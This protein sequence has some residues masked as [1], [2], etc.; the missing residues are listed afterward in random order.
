M[1]GEGG[2]CSTCSRKHARG[3][4]D[5]RR[6][7]GGDAAAQEAK[8]ARKQQTERLALL[9]LPFLRGKHLMLTEKAN[10]PLLPKKGESKK[11]EEARVKQLADKIAACKQNA[12]VFTRV[13]G[14]VLSEGYKWEPDAFFVREGHHIWCPRGFDRNWW[15]NDPEKAG[16]WVQ[17]QF[18]P[19]ER[20][21]VQVP[22]AIDPRTHTKSMADYKR[23]DYNRALAVLGH[24]FA[25]VPRAKF[26][27]AEGKVALTNWESVRLRI[28][29]LVKKFHPD[30]IPAECEVSDVWN[31]F[32][33]VSKVC[34]A[35]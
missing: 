5:P 18:T 29:D 16:K 25:I 23:E 34:C 6:T 9:E 28:T 15:E 12:L 27:D 26:T 11:D 19:V 13:C 22:K 8:A 1:C 17:T 2:R 35:L 3:P 20:V 14:K 33:S 7:R 4:V 31:A 10:P 21:H 32:D 30:K 24:G